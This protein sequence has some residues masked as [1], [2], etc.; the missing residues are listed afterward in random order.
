MKVVIDVH[1]VTAKNTRGIPQYTIN[2]VRHLLARKNNEYGL[3]YYD[4]MKERNNE[5]LVLK[6]FGDLSPALYECMSM[7]RSERLLY[8]AF[9]EN[10]YS[11]CMGTN[12]DLYHFTN[13]SD[14]PDNITDTKKLSKN[15]DS[16]A[17]VT[18]HDITPT[19]RQ[20]QQINHSYT[21]GMHRIEKLQ[22]I[23]I[24]DTYAAKEELCALEVVPENNIHVVHLGIDTTVY[25]KTTVNSASKFGI[26]NPYFVVL[27]SVGEFR[28]NTS[29]IVEAFNIIAQKYEVSLVFLGKIATQD[30]NKLVDKK[31]I[32]DKIIFTDFISEEEKISLL[33]NA[34][35]LIFPSLYEGFGLPIL[36][37][38]AC[39]VPVITSELSSMP[40]V[41][42][43]SAILVDPYS[44]EAI[45]DAM[46]RVLNDTQLCK[47]LIKKGYENIKRFSWDKCA[48]QTEEVY[49][50]A[51]EKGR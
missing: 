8:N 32:S 37:A 47:D 21:I 51:Y 3:A 14:I 16:G 7:K 12:A 46:E 17:V 9:K 15:G 25:E 6:H 45:A 4:Y 40:E 29:R 41:A 10:S 38:Q 43:N 20:L 36:E 28:K 1:C 48:A 49:K 23:I 42:G 13:T 19:I 27:G 26:Y 31:S 22:P 33:S 5:A 34:A 35:S 18:C 39:G 30:L 2:L 24:T 44:V 11:L 50:I